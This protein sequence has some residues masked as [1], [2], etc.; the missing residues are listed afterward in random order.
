M[1][2]EVRTPE[3]FPLP[4]GIVVKWEEL[5]YIPEITA[6]RYALRATDVALPEEFWERC[7]CNGISIVGGA[8]VEGTSSVVTYIDSADIHLEPKY[9]AFR[10]WGA[11]V[12]VHRKDDLVDAIRRGAIPRR[13]EGAPF[14]IIPEKVPGPQEE[15]RKESRGKKAQR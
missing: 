10:S 7:A 3:G 1:L 14:D 13:N 2:P 4:H 11:M 6:W 9:I 8:M 15:P 5:Q 12:P